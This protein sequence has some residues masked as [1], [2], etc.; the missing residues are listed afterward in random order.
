MEKVIEVNIGRINFNIEEDAYMKLKSY[1]T[2]FEGSL[3]DKKDA[4][5][6]MEDVESRVAELFQK[7]VK[8]PNQVVD[9][10]MVNNVISCLGEID[11]EKTNTNQSTEFKMKTDKK[12]YRNPEDKKIAGVC[13]GLAIYFGIDPTLIRV[14]FILVIFFGFGSPFIVY[15]VLWIA[16]PEAN[17]V[18]QKMEMYGE[19]VTAENIKNYTTGNA[20]R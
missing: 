13:G 14:L 4:R 11:T 6:I 12:L 8:Y 19:A 1:L 15:F 9:M 20:R 7:E 5:E 18:V 3:P 17:T 2:D 10:N 16:M